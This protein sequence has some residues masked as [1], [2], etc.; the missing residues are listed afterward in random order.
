M[1]CLIVFFLATAALT[2]AQE[3]P[4]R[5]AEL[6]LSGDFLFAEG[7]I[8][9]IFE[10]VVPNIRVATTEDGLCSWTFRL[11]FSRAPGSE[12]LRP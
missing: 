11:I 5:L 8:G 7:D 1:L 4:A 9:F 10:F 2:R 6:T 3:K 12:Q